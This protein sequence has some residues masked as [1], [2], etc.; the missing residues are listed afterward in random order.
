LKSDD[1]ALLKEL[2]VGACCYN[3]VPAML[4]AAHARC[5]VLA[6]LVPAGG[7]LPDA[8]AKQLEELTGVQ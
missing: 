5:R 3:A 7:K 8:L 4:I 1:V 6:L 2:G